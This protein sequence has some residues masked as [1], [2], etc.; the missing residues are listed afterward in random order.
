MTYCLNPTCSKPQNLD[1]GKFCTNCGSKLRLGE[2]FR[3][4]RK[5]NQGGFGRTFL[6]IDEGNP[7][8]KKCVIKQISPDYQK[9]KN[10]QEAKEKF[11][12]ICE[13]LQK[14]GEHPQ[15]PT[16][17]GYFEGDSLTTTPNLPTV[18]QEL[19]SG[20]SLQEELRNQGAWQE[21]QV[22]D[23]LNKLLPIL[24]FIHEQGVIHRDLNPNNIICSSSPAPTINNPQTL[25]KSEVETNVVKQEEKKIFLVDF[26]TAKVITKTALSKKQGTVIGSASYTAPE[27][28]I[29]Q[30]CYASDLYSLGVICI[31]LLTQ[32]EPFDLFSRYEAKWVWQDYLL[33]PVSNNLGKIINKMLAEKL[34]ER[35][36][37]A[38]EI[39]QELN[40]GQTIASIPSQQS[41]SPK[42]TLSTLAP[43][44]QCLETLKGHRS[45]VHGISFSPDG[46]YVASCGA[47]RSVKIWHLDT[48][49]L[50]H[51][52]L[53]HKSLVEK[54]IFTP[55]GEKIISGSWDNQIKIWHRETGEAVTNLIGHTGWVKALVIYPDDY[56]LVSGSADKS[57]KLWDLNNYEISYTFPTQE[58]A[59][60][61]LAISPD[62][63]SLV[64]G[65]SDGTIKFWDLASYELKQ[66]IK[67]HEQQVNSLVF[68]P[69]GKIV[70]SAS[71][72]GN[73][74]FWQ[75]KSGKLLKTIASPAIPINALAINQE[76][77]FLIS[78]YE[79][80][81][82]KIYH[83]SSGSL[84]YELTGHY[85]GVLAVDI[86]SDNK[87]IASASRDKTIKL[88]QFS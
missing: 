33:H 70:I 78:A 40:S 62:G 52:F 56:S 63:Y 59:I 67:A 77:N 13:Q 1:T 72:D 66:E 32:I 4:I 75:L 73:I 58:N 54:V 20:P 29:G 23:I 7:Q 49:K 21:N 69:S 5:I 36:E 34:S 64:S 50:A 39:F 82:I 8:K 19:I 83:P 16:L 60:Q 84:L 68:S 41:A 6:G 10:P 74:K 53:G 61:S 35:Y 26:S 47:D 31:Y 28:L 45:S 85:S 80:S 55:E 25:A 43:T 79:D 14:I 81:T 27:Q 46:D 76:G 9:A 44:W 57:I 88:W 65:S 51:S 2:R 48:R 87:T 3:A 15:I 37:S 18:V 22:R 30:A 86:S 24:Q 17:L 12:K 71:A 11:R 42:S 38:T